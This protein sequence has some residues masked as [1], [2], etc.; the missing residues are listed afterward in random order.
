MNN[1][2]LFRVGKGM[3]QDELATAAGITQSMVSQ[4]E[5][6][7]KKPSIEVAEKMAVAL[8][9]DSHDLFD[10]FVLRKDKLMGFW[11]KLSTRQMDTLIEFA[12]FMAERG[13]VK[14]S[15]QQSYAKIACTIEFLHICLDKYASRVVNR[16]HA[17]GANEFVAFVVRQLRA[18]A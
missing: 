11:R 17:Y 16:E 15:H 4:L 1:I 14:N 2:K 8:N 9:C 6:G 18:S 3:R 5:T 7:E 10:G 12:Q 13:I